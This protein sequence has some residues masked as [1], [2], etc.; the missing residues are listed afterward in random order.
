MSRLDSDVSAKPSDLDAYCAWHGRPPV[1]VAI[2]LHNVGEKFGHQANLVVGA[3]PRPP[4]PISK[5]DLEAICVN[6]PL[7][8]T[9]DGSDASIADPGAAAITSDDPSFHDRTHG[10]G[11]RKRPRMQQT[12]RQLP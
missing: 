9:P 3:L 8:D 5:P 6:V 12:P 10:S 11:T 4:E 2:G 7:G 1:E